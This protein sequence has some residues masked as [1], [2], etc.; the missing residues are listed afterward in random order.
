MGTLRG[1]MIAGAL[2]SLVAAL[3]AG[4]APWPVLSGCRT[5]TLFAP[6]LPVLSLASVF[7]GI[8]RDTR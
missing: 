5:T 4:R 1:D 7:K 2:F 8:H 6:Q 3:L